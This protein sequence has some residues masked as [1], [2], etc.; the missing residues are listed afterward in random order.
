MMRKATDKGRT[1]I[2][3]GTPSMP[4]MSSASESPSSHNP[5]H[6]KPS[7]YLHIPVTQ[8]QASDPPHAAN[9]ALT[10]W[11][12]PPQQVCKDGATP[13]AVCGRYSTALNDPPVNPI[14][15]GGTG[16]YKCPRCH[17]GYSRIDTVRQHFPHCIALN[18]NP[19]CLSW[20]DDDS[21][22]A[23]VADRSASKVE[24]RVILKARKPSV[25]P[26]PHFFYSKL[27]C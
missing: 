23:G 26:N 19:D 11:H 14:T 8:P 24:G 25:Q 18:G 12:V 5:R 16:P 13:T 21:Y 7:A 6:R 20:T 3:N 17:V 10:L 15:R 2:S 27:V 4:E 22:A 9:L 1:T